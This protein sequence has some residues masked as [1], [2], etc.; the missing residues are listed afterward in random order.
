MSARPRIGELCVMFLQ[1]MGGVLERGLDQER[2]R[3]PLFAPVALGVGVAIWQAFGEIIFWP[4][5]LTCG[6]IFFFAAAIGRQRKFGQFLIVA[7]VLILTG[8]AAISVKSRYTAAS[9]LQHIWIGEIYGQVESVE[10]VSAR[11]IVRLILKTNSELT[12]PR[13]IRVNVSTEKYRNEIRSGAIIRAKVRLMPPPGPSLPGGYDFARQ[14]WF[15][16]LGATGSVLGEVHIYQKSTG[17]LSVW[18]MWRKKISDHVQ[19]QMPNG[20]WGNWL[21]VV[22]RNEGDHI[23]GGRRST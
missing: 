22:G 6:A 3:L 14:A 4:L 7:A 18:Q 5:L 10:D 23:R 21:G 20:E 19:M 11:G 8:F 9:P 17:T 12:I 2:D 13:R 15:Q 16:G 1:N